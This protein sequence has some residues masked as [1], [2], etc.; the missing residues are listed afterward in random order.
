MGYARCEFER[1]SL[2]YENNYNIL[3]LYFDKIDKLY[4]DTTY[5]ESKMCL[6]R[7]SDAIQF[8]VNKCVM[9]LDD[10]HDD[11]VLLIG[12]YSIRKRDVILKQVD[13]TMTIN[14]IFN[15]RRQNRVYLAT[16]V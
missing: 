15:Y 1:N 8:I 16:I 2:F 5:V 4:V 11:V 7:Q 12:T 6:P 10:Y 14:S 13:D 3:S 9:H